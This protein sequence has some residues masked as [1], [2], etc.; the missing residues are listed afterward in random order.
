MDRITRINLTNVRTYTSASLDLTGVTVLIGDNGVGK[1]TIIEVCEILRRMAST[2]FT[3]QFF[4]FHRAPQLIRA[5]A[6]RMEIGVT[7]TSDVHGEFP[8]HYQATWESRGGVLAVVAEIIDYGPLPTDKDPTRILQRTEAGGWALEKGAQ[9]PL[10]GPQLDPSRL[11]LAV[12]HLLSHP[13]VARLCSALEKIHVHLPLDLSPAWAASAQQRPLGVRGASPL[14]PADRVA[15]GATNLANVYQALKNDFGDDHWQATMEVVRLG[16]GSNVESVSVRPDAASNVALWLKYRVPDMQVPAAGL[17]DGILAWLAF[18]ALDRFPAPRSLLAIDE[19]DL[20]LHPYL[21]SRV[22]DLCAATSSRHP[23]LLTT[24]SDRLLD[25]LPAPSEQVVLAQSNADGSTSLLRPDP[26][27][28][29]A[30]LE[31][32]SGYGRVRAEGYEYT[33]YPGKA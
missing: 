3:G 14:V 15:L 9:V 28:L 32:Y 13:S 5:G 16:L 17:S 23:V 12:A 31:R 30:W 8:V 4:G 24:H 18:V 21:L 27:T 11:N 26:T 6:T 19:V 20:H 7:V 1:S 10:R 22:L 2:E 25:M 29:A 33:M